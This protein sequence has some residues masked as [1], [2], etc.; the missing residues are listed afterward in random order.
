MDVESLQL[1]S[2][3]AAASRYEDFACLSEPEHFGDA[4]S[5]L[6]N[7]KQELVRKV[8]EGGVGFIL[9]FHADTTLA[10]RE[11]HCGSAVW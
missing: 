6:E 3:Y 5:A 1:V 7:S 9:R 8:Q 4:V 11:N 10:N 2:Y